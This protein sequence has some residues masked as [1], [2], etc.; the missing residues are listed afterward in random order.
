MLN[1]DRLKELLNYNPINGEFKWLQSRG[2]ISK[3]H[4]AGST[5]KRDGYVYIRIDKVSYGAHRLAILYMTGILPNVVDHDDRNQENNVYSNL[6]DGTHQD[7][8]RNLSKNKSNTSG[9]TGV[10]KIKGTSRYKVNI[11]VSGKTIHIGHYEDLDE[12]IAARE[13][14][15]IKHGFNVN[16]GK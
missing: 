7:N 15:Q 4:I 2:R 9:H 13:A 6:K 14:A 8:M 5:N 11:S 12:A 16:H 3:G 1:Q 10:C